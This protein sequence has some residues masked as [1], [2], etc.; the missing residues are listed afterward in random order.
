MDHTA[1]I[2][3]PQDKAPPE[4]R[5]VPEFDDETGRLTGVTLTT[6][7]PREGASVSVRTERPDLDAAVPPLPGWHWFEDRGDI[8]CELAPTTQEVLA[9]VAEDMFQGTLGSYRLNGC[10]EPVDQLPALAELM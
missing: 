8:V 1:E 5:A 6:K 9:Q 4:M 3:E 7:P 10:S 2:H